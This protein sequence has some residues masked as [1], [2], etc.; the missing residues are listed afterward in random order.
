[1]KLVPAYLDVL[2]RDKGLSNSKLS[3]DAKVSAP[4]IGQIRS[5]RY[6]PYDGE[7]LRI[8]KVLNVDNPETLLRPINLS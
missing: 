8:A 4:R 7:L 3:R 1:M 2:M 6:I 5:G